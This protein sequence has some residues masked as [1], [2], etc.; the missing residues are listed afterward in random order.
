MEVLGLGSWP[1]I[2]AAGFTIGFLIGMTGVGAGSLTTPVLIS[3]FGVPPAIAVGTDLLFAAITKASSAWRHHAFGNVDWRIVR[4]LATGSLL[5]ACLTLGWLYFAQ[6]DVAALAAIIRKVLAVALV[7]SAVAI[8]IYSW[9]N[10][11]NGNTAGDGAD[12]APRRIATVAFGL[13][14]GALVALTSVGAGAIG[15]AALTALYPALRARRL[16]GTDIVHAIPLTLVAGLGHL[17]LGNVDWRILAALLA[18]SIPGIAIGARI[19][20]AIPD[21]VLRAALAIVLLYAAY[22]M[23]SKT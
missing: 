2:A 11:G 6:P 5:A 19:T 8:P 1:F 14:V 9:K 21:W 23:I 10:R 20:G 13:V 18:G 17:G 16:V 7:A 15:V 22:V 12:V 3:A 4:W